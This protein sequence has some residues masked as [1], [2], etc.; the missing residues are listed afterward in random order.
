MWIFLLVVLAGIAG[1]W[2]IVQ[3]YSSA[4]AIRHV[5]LISLDTTRA[6]HVSCYGWSRPTTPNIDALASEGYLFKHALTPVPL[7]LPAHTSMLTGTIPPHHGKRKNADVYFDPSHVTLAQLLKDKGYSTGA[8]VGA[9]VLNSSFGL[10]RGFDTYQD[11]FANQDHERPAGDVNR[12]AFAWLDQQK[13]NPVFLFMHYYDAHDEYAPPEPFA[14]SFN[15]DPYSGEIAYTDHCIGEV[16]AKLKSLG[17]YDSSL[18]IVTG[19]HGEMLGEH[20]ELTHMYFI[21]QSALKVPLVF[22]LPGSGAGQQIDDLAGIIDIVPTVCDLVGV[23]APAGIEGQNLAGYFGNQ[24]PLPEDRYLYCES[25][26][27]TNYGA[28]SFVGLASTRWKYIHTTRPELY[29]LLNDPGEQNNLIEDQARQASILEENLAQITELAARQGTVQQNAPLDPDLLHHLRSLGYVGESSA[30]EDVSFE[31]GKEDPKDLIDYHN[32]WC[33]AEHLVA[34]HKLDEALNVIE[35]ALEQRTGYMLCELATRI[36][37]KQ[38]DYKNAIRYGE[39]ALAEKPGYFYAHERLASAYSFDKQD[40]LAA[41][42]FELAL[43]VMPEDKPDFLATRARLHFQLAMTRARQEKFDLALAQFNE[44]LALDPRQ[45]FLLNALA[46]LLIDC[47]DRALRDPGRALELAQ[48]ACTLTQLKNPLYL[49]TLALA[50]AELNNIGSAVKITG[51][52]L[53]LAAASGDDALVAELR[54][55]LDSLRRKD[56]AVN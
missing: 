20:G 18:I 55:Q 46:S 15:E 26:H 52:A 11:Q 41:R 54:A 6:D 35:T 4:P 49:K 32:A 24:P 21:Y 47:P 2:L 8:F 12:A 23:D 53:A 45:P 1:T 34:D 50:Y 25:M 14:S 39:M 3:R 27:P 19:D 17:M 29:D 51:N 22:K 9:Q 5:I 13:D 36:C 56:S 38:Q 16:V 33:K 37:L 44:A 30:Q 40:E 42:Q 7:T 31:P 28:N 48:Q 43:Q 10:N